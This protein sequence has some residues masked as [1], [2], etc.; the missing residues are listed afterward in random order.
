M[1]NVNAKTINELCRLCRKYA[2]TGDA[3]ICSAKIEQARKMSKEIF[4]VDDWWLSILDFVDSLCGVQ[5]IKKCCNEEI[6]RF[7]EMLGIQVVKDDSEGE[8]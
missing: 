4:S 7:L 3:D 5:P 8:K 6:Y 2:K 1:K